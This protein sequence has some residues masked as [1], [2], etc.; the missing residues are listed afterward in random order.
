MKPVKEKEIGKSSSK[1][2]EEWEDECEDECKDEG[3]NYLSSSQKIANTKK[4]INRTKTS[5]CWKFFKE[6]MAFTQ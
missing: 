3:E 4:K 1:D 6:K 2:D 5:Q